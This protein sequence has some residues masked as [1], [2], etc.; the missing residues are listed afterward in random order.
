MSYFV[1][2]VNGKMRRDLVS[3]LINPTTESFRLIFNQFGLNDPWIKTNE[4][5]IIGIRPILKTARCK[6]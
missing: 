1:T 5:F 2:Q 4:H 3:N 6:Q